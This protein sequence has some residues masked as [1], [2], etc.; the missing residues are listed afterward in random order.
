MNQNTTIKV[1]LLDQDPV[2]YARLSDLLALERDIQLFSPVVREN[3]LRQLS[4]LKP[5][6]LIL[7]YGLFG[8][9]STFLEATAAVFP[10]L[11]LTAASADH[12]ISAFEL[13]AVDYLL[14]PVEDWRLQLTLRRL[15]TEV[16]KH[17]KAQVS[18]DVEKLAE[19][20]GRQLEQQPQQ[21]AVAN[22]VPM[23]F[24]RR[25]RF[26][27]VLDI[28]C[29]SARG[30]YVTIKTAAGDTLN[31]S[32]SISVMERKLPPDLFI[33]VNRSVIVNSLFIQ[34]VLT[35]NR[36]MKVILKDKSVFPVGTT[37]KSKFGRFLKAER[38][39]QTPENKIRPSFDQIQTFMSHSKF[40]A[41]GKS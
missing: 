5:D 9:V 10:L 19:F 40:A 21:L 33:R 15:R 13:G 4:I 14:K 31:S 36:K 2:A 23:R 24:G 37:Y 25:H 11:V 8:T 30:T 7:D 35:A 22:R 41:P 17:R 18:F 32:D 20:V 12:A 34:E 38:A 28:F 26:I 3:L 6:V 16:E 1:L 29:I 27:D 39:T